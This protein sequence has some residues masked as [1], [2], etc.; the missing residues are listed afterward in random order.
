MK[1]HSAAPG[2]FLPTLKAL[3]L[4]AVLAMGLTG[5][6][7]H[8]V[9]SVPLVFYPPP[10]NAPRL[11][12][13]KGITNSRD[14]EIQK[15]QFSLFL[16]GNKE[17]DKV[18]MI[19]K[20][21]GLTYAKG[22]LYLCDM[23]GPNVVIMDLVK[24]TFDYLKGNKGYGRLK[25]PVNVALDKHGNIFVVDV[26]RKEVLMYDPEGNFLKT[27]GK[28]EVKKPV[29]V[30]SDD[31][32]V[33][34]L[35]LADNDIKVFDLK[36]GK[37]SRTIGKTEGTTQGLS[38]PTNFTTDGKGFLYTTNVGTGCVMKLDRDGHIL[39]RFGKIGDA[40]GEFVR[41][42]G[43]AVDPLNRIFVVDGGHQNVQIFNDKDR[44]LM[45]FGD[46]P[47]PAGMLN[48]PAGIAV[49]TQNL[50][51]F[52]KL[53]APGFMLQEVIFVTNQMGKDKV[54][55]YGLGQ[56]KDEATTAKLEKE[57]EKERE[58]AKK[59]KKSE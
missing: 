43:I 14:V 40:F 31:Q 26:M 52:Q 38:I 22:K 11:Q 18:K 33:Y 32:N 56:M 6:A 19:K 50:D 3:C 20:P 1:K 41:P 13:L 12:Y 25:K 27:Y 9:N 58:Q 23:Q 42:K 5:C 4:F 35:D 59:A 44:L 8:K 54:S 29:D 21:Y 16:V 55:I 36:T 10:P 28:K 7:A 37:L 57:M 34:I 24:G 49:T 51:Y 53:A 39:G 45:F 48:L 47:N 17:E 46:T 15:D 2:I 30:T